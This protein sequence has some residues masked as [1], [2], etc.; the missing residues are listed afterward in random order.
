[1]FPSPRRVSS[2]EDLGPSVSENHPPT[3]EME[4]NS[5]TLMVPLNGLW[6]S[7]SVEVLFTEKND[8][9]NLSDNHE[10][11][12]EDSPENTT[13][14]LESP[15]KDS[16]PVFDTPVTPPGSHDTDDV[17]KVET[18]REVM[19]HLERFEQNEEG[20][21]KKPIILSTSSVDTE[22]CISGTYPIKLSR[23][24]I[25]STTSLKSISSMSDVFP[26]TNI[27]GESKMDSVRKM[28]G[29]NPPLWEE[30]EN[31]ENNVCTHSEIIET[32]YRSETRQNQYNS[33]L[34]YTEESEMHFTHIT[35][36]KQTK[37]HDQSH[38][39][40]HTSSS[41]PSEDQ[42]RASSSSSSHDQTHTSSTSSTDD[43]ERPG[44]ERRRSSAQMVADM[45]LPTIP[46]LSVVVPLAVLTAISISKS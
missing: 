45:V 19:E 11:E 5:S 38:D 29:L 24:S 6:K 32:S 31:E 33:G 40:R 22:S 12:N 26:N 15:R 42:R 9:E 23:G 46:A 35:M 18:S 3:H 25:E 17:I 10:I 27:E 37:T 8:F 13:I 16:L 41:T 20:S 7:R 39:R 30:N 21:I 1:M 28:S 43:I 2:V 4:V 36:I 14:V 34:E 44:T